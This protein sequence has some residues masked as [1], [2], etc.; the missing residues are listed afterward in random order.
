MGHIMLVN[1]NVF[2][3]K[4]TQTAISVKYSGEAAKAH[5]TDVLG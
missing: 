5:I 2:K 4:D 3:I 1:S